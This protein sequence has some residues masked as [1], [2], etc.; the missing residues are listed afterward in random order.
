MPFFSIDNSAL[1]SLFE[2]INLLSS[3]EYKEGD[4]IK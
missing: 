2:S 4:K 1:I 3:G